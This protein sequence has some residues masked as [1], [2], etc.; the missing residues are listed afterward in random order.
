M[1]ELYTHILGTSKALHWASEQRKIIDD[2][3]AYQ[4][5]LDFVA[6]H[7]QVLDEAR[8]RL[9][10]IFDMED[11]RSRIAEPTPYIM[12][13]IQVSLLVVLR[14]WY[15]LS[16][17]LRSTTNNLEDKFFIRPRLS[18]PLCLPLCLFKTQRWTQ[19]AQTFHFL[20]VKTQTCQ[21]TKGATNIGQT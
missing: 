7:I 19:F 12:V 3:T 18:N 15:H 17:Y 2:Q 9:P 11:I 14:F 13:A 1:D 10:E 8:D 4:M 20:V 16:I 5:L 21:N 6:C